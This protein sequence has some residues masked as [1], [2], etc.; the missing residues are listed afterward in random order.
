VIVLANLNLFPQTLNH[1][2]LAHF[3][4]TTEPGLVAN[5]LPVAVVAGAFVAIIGTI[6]RLSAFRT[7]GRHFTFQLTLSDDHQLVTSYPYNIVRHPGYTALY[8]VYLGLACS[9]LAPDGWLRQV[10]LPTALDLSASRGT[11]ARIMMITLVTFHVSLLSAMV[12]R[13]RDED[14]LLQCRFG[15][16]WDAWAQSVPY[17]IVPFVW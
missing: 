1:S 15:K 10:V 17:R 9:L 6:L 7:L 14:V 4:G 5:K 2:V 12:P 3:T 8:T 11:E 13:A 16:H